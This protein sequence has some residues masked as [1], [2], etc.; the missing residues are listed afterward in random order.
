MLVR[1]TTHFVIIICPDDCSK[2]DTAGHK[3][4]VASNDG[5]KAKRHQLDEACADGNAE[6]SLVVDCMMAW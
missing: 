5:H 3:A 2:R 1:T 4:I 6:G